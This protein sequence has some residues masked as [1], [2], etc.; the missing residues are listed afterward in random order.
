MPSKPDNPLTV[1]CSS[2]IAKWFALCLT[3]AALAVLIIMFFE[4]VPFAA[5]IDGTKSGDPEGFDYSNAILRG[6]LWVIALLIPF[7][8]YACAVVLSIRLSQDHIFLWASVGMLAVLSVLP[9]MGLLLQ[10]A[11]SQSPIRHI[12][13]AALL[14]ALVF[15]VGLCAKRLRT[16]ARE[17]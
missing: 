4:V 1:G 3:A 17:S 14:V 8:T 7:A 12:H 9:V 13:W 10:P 2:R 15:G 11:D 5:A 6:R 16:L